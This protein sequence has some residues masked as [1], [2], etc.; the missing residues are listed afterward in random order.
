MNEG[1]LRRE[2]KQNFAK[3]LNCEVKIGAKGD[4]LPIGTIVEVDTIELLMLEACGGNRIAVSGVKM[5]EICDQ[6]LKISFT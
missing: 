4:I 6:C 3:I 2:A 1:T 5:L